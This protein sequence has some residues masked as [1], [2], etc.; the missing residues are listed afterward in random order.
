MIDFFPIQFYALIYYNIILM[1]V[2]VIFFHT[3]FT[4]SENY[5]NITTLKYFGEV[6]FLFLIIYM[7][8]RPING[9]FIDMK[10]YANIFKS[11]QEGHQA[12]KIDYPF[13]ISYIQF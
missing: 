12:F 5:E 10:T 9:F 11:Y 6:I 1:V 4:N 8:L 3:Q 13:F 7:G 2:L